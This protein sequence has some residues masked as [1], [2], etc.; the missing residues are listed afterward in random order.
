MTNYFYWV[1]RTEEGRSQQLV[2]RVKDSLRTASSEGEKT[3][4]PDAGQGAPGEWP[5]GE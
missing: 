3:E 4:S 5:R 2:Y 1:A